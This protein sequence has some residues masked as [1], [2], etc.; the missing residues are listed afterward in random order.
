MHNPIATYPYK[1]H[2]IEIYPDFD[3]ESPREWD[4]LGTLACFHGRYRLGDDHNFSSPTD[5]AKH[6]CDIDAISL[7]VYLMDH[8]GLAVN[9]TGFSCP[10]DSGLVGCIYVARE[11]VRQEY[12]RQR[13]SQK[14]EHQVLDI[15]RAEVETYSMYL[16]GRV[17]GYVVKDRDGDQIDS[18]WGFF[19]EY[20]GYI[21][22]EAKSVIDYQ[23]SQIPEI[24]KAFDLV[25]N[26]LGTA[27]EQIWNARN[28]PL[29]NTGSS[30]S[31]MF[32][33]SMMQRVKA[34]RQEARDIIK[35][36]NLDK[37]EIAHA[38]KWWTQGRILPD[39]KED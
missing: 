13:I 6:M 17:Y 27:N 9:T 4:N 8:S 36:Y 26:L 31:N 30:M 35:E 3:P 34:M 15:L 39:M 21:L 25:V 5:L 28:N 16:E 38:V 14:L 7:P 22:D 23:I 10:W 24:T 12:D 11:T 32:Y 1:G 19:C 33:C 29:F 2:T 20:D 18:C 37:R